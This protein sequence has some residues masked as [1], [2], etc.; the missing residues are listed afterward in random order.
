MVSALLAVLLGLLLSS[1]AGAREGARGVHCAARLKDLGVAS[2]HY[3]ILFDDWLSGSPG[4]SGL[5]LLLAS[6]PP[7]SLDLPGLPTQVWDWAAPVAYHGLNLQDLPENRA[8]RFAALREGP[9]SCRSNRYLSRAYPDTAAEAGWPAVLRSASYATVREFLYFGKQGNTYD[10]VNL[11]FWW[12]IR[13]PSSYRPRLN[14]LVRA[15]EKIW[16]AEGTPWWPADDVHDA[17]IGY[18]ARYGGAFSAAGAPSSFSR[19]YANNVASINPADGTPQP[20]LRDRYA[21]RHALSAGQ[22]GMQSLRFDGH[23]APLSKAEAIHNVDL[24]YPSGSQV[25]A[26][27]F[28]AGPFPK[29]CALQAIAARGASSEGF[30]PIY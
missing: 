13:T 14:H 21:Y 18:K 12:N 1:L 8:G 5:P 27:E 4:T 26:T 3:A 16:L 29:P 10:G 7:A 22:P 25:K 17:P 30:Y 11:P 15:A 24:W 20:A 6:A 23:V 2:M 9:F 19:G 28:E